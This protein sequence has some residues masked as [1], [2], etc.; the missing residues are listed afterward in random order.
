MSCS[1]VQ[2]PRTNHSDRT[3]TQELSGSLR[4]SQEESGIVSKHEESS[5]K[6]P[7][8]SW[9]IRN[10]Q[11]AFVLKAVLHYDC[12]AHI[13]AAAAALA[14]ASKLSLQVDHVFSGSS[15]LVFYP[16]LKQAL[17]S[18]IFLY[19]DLKINKGSMENPCF[20]KTCWWNENR[21]VPSSEF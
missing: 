17:V 16:M 13:D 10:C 6:G 15:A 9:S 20:Q 5:T 14:I 1:E 12:L 18:T 7:K 19:Q 8:A 11:E 3:T 4:K 21:F 2:L